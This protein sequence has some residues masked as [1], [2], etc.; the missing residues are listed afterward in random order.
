M[1]SL[2]T[3]VEQ[4][5]ALIGT[6]DLNNWETDFMVSVSEQVETRKTTVYLSSKQIENIEKIYIKNF[7]D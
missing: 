3:M 7:G 4:L 5:T 1:K 2:N 6:A